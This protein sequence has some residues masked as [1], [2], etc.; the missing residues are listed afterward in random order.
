[1]INTSQFINIIFQNQNDDYMLRLIDKRVTS[2][3]FWVTTAEHGTIELNDDFSFTIKVEVYEDD[4]KTLVD[5]NM[6]LGELLRIMVLQN[7]ERDKSS[8][9]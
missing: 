4:E 1:M 2:M 7:R 3:R 9:D 5:Q 8:R 6:G